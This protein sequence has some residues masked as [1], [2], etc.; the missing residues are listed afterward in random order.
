VKKLSALVILSAL[1]LAACGTSP[2]A[3]AATVDGDQITVGEVNDLIHIEDG[4]VSK[5]DFAEFL[6]IR[7]QWSVM[8]RAASEEYGIQ[9]SEEEITAEAD[10]IYAEF[11]ADGESREEFTASRGV[12]EEFLRQVA[13][14][15]L[16]DEILRE[17]FLGEGR[18]VPT[19]E[20]IDERLEGATIELSEVC[21]SH[22]LLGQ[23]AT[24]EGEELEEATDAAQA[25]AEAVLARLAAGE[26]FAEIAMEVSADP[27]SGAM[28]GDLGCNTPARYVDEFRDAAMIAPIGEVLSEPV[29]SQFGF[30]V[31]LVHSRTVPTEEEVTDTLKERGLVTELQNWV[32]GRLVAAAVVIES[33]FGTWETTP[34]P[35]VVAPVD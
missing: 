34:Q 1:V 30:H 7:I 6:G 18:G 5:D 20:E 31:I 35:R 19:R 15:G 17:R 9:I 22:I 27:G 11:A 23:L 14:Q 33:R 8:E 3:V 32:L 4:T 21:V 13:H 24:L 12:T 26:D 29:K 25:E 16:I 28:G 2:G 10:R